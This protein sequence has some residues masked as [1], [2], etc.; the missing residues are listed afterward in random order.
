MTRHPDRVWRLQGAPNFRDL[1]GYIGHQGRPL[2]W[3]HLFRSDHLAGLTADDH[4]RLAPL[5]LARAF[6][7]RGVD[8]RAS[9]PYDLPG[10]TQ[11]SLAI[12]PTVV[13]RMNELTAA[14]H[15][16]TA[17]L[18][19]QL[20]N[21]LYRAL[22]NDRADRFGEL[23]EH[24]LDSDAPAVF[25]C[26][27]G[28]DRTGVAAALVLLALG[29]P[30]DVVLQDYL[31]TNEFAMPLPPPHES[32]MPIEALAVLWRVQQDFLDTALH[33]IDTDH[34]GIGRYLRQ[35]L[36]LSEAALAALATRYL[37]TD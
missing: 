15:A 19:T 16:L 10:V 22:I 23:F 2:R 30:R 17:P 36:R 35:R 11:V 1:G 27:A 6:D 8:E 9:A 18:V 31:L 34:G 13:Q 28:K 20:M 5:R 3:R 21:D 32:S 4:A 12:E 7:F 25:H 24:L 26:T 37:R 14:G 29:V 33:I